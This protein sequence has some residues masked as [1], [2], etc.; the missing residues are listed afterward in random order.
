[1]QKLKYGTKTV[2]LAV[3]PETVQHEIYQS[4]GSSPDLTF[5]GAVTQIA[6]LKASEP[7]SDDAAGTDAALANLRQSLASFAQEK[8]A[9]K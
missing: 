5:K 4:S 9:K 6:T 7:S 3:S 8:E 2:Q 1:L